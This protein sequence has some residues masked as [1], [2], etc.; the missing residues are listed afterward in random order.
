MIADLDTPEDLRRWSSRQRT[1]ECADEVHAH[2]SDAAPGGSAGNLHVQVRLFALAKERVGRA[3]IDLELP[4]G[5][6]V[7]GLR[8]AL[9][10]RFPAIAPLMRTALFAINEEY[11]G[12]DAPVMAG[13]R[14]A[15]IPPVSGGLG[16]IGRLAERGSRL[17]ANGREIGA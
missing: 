15:V 13:S 9:G 10:E 2:P 7:A 8:T 6:R 4:A 11:A 3:V 12:D 16:P 17:L 14:I 1:D 5:S